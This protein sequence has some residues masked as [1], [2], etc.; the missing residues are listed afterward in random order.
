MKFQKG[1]SGNPKG[2]PPGKTH[3]REIRELLAKAAPDVVNMTYQRAMEGDATAL[4]ILMDRLIPPLRAQ[5]QPT[6]AAIEGDT[7]ADKAR[8]IMALVS[9]GQLS[10]DQADDLMATLVSM[11]RIVETTEILDRIEQLEAH[12]GSQSLNTH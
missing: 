12:Y 3:S 11:T 10:T 9:T 7:P 2:R 5:S 8:H 6:Q 4:K 1:Q